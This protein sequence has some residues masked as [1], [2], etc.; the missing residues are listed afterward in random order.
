MAFSTSL[1]DK[2][3]IW[4]QLGSG[5]YRTLPSESVGDG[6]RPCSC[7]R[8]YPLI[9]ACAQHIL[10]QCRTTQGEYG[11]PYEPQKLVLFQQRGLLLFKLTIRD[12][13]AHDRHWLRAERFPETFHHGHS[14]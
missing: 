4:S 10:F 11:G 1:R 9:R 3:V 13:E 6:V 14:S 5:Q 8:E 2:N 12:Y 7:L